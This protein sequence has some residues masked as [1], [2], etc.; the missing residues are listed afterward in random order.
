MRVSCDECSVFPLKSWL[1]GSI[2]RVRAPIRVRV[3]VRAP[4]RV[5]V[6]VRAPVR[7]EVRVEVC[8]RRS[9]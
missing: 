3:R 9:V 8:F 6:R 4:V 7:V 5:K 1:E 2:L